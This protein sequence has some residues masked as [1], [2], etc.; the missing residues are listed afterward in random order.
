MS[1]LDDIMLDGA[2]YEPESNTTVIAVVAI[3]VLCCFCSCCCCSITEIAALLLIEYG[4][5]E[6]TSSLYDKIFIPSS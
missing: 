4:D 5:Y 6:W 1:D 2:M 3:V